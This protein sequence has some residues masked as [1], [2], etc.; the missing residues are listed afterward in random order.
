MLGLELAASLREETAGGLSS[1]HVLTFNRTGKCDCPG[2]A[3]MCTKRS[4]T[5]VC[6][7]YSIEVQLL[8]CGQSRLK[9]IGIKSGSL[10]SDCDFALGLPRNPF[11]YRT[12][13]GADG[14][15]A[16]GSHRSRI[17]ADQ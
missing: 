8:L 13:C 15:Q 16:A 9:G 4:S 12:G 17:P 6:D 10:D 11:Q 1:V 2:I 7:D 3:R 5:R 14:L